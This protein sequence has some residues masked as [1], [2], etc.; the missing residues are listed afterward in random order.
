MDVTELLHDLFRRRSWAD[1]VELLIIGAA[2]NA[3]MRFLRGTRGARQLRGFLFLLLGSTLILNLIANVFDLERIKTLY[4]MFVGALFLSALVAF[5]TELRRALIRLG[6]GSW[7]GETR[8]DFDRLVDEVVEAVSQLSRERKGALI[9]FER[10]TEFRALEESGVKLDADLSKE[11]LV[12][13]FWPGSPLHDM[14][15]IVS[16]GRISSAAVQFP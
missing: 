6:A 12:T 5:Q 9:A 3:V 1:L 16:Q 13:I 14:G 8:G 7:L 11:L 10:A 2:V 4:P 15:V